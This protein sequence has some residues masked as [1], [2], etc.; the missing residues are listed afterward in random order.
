MGNR[1]RIPKNTADPEVLK[2]EKEET[3][4]IKSLVRDERTHKILGSV[5][6]FLGLFL[7]VAFTSYLFTWMEDQDKVRDMG[8]KILMPNE[9]EISNQLGSLGAFTAFV[10]FE[11]GFGLSSYLFCSLFFVLGSNLMFDKPI[12][13]V[14][15]NLRYLLTG[16][17]IGSVSAAFF[18]PT[19]AFNWGG[20]LGKFAAAWLTAVIGWAGTF[21]LI[22][23]S[24]FSYV[25]W[26]FNPI[27]KWPVFSA[28]PKNDLQDLSLEDSA[29]PPV[30][31]PEIIQPRLDLTEGNTLKPQHALSPL[32]EHPV[33]TAPL[34]VVEKPADEI[35]AVAIAPLD[36]PWEADEIEEESN[37]EA[38]PPLEI[39]PVL[40]EKNISPKAAA[41]LASPRYDPIADLKG[42]KFPSLDLLAQHTG[43]KIVMD[44]HELE[45]NKTQIMSTLRNYDI[46]IQKIFATVGPT[47]TLYEIVPAAGVRISRIKNLEDDIA[48][49]LSAL[50]IRIPCHHATSLDGW[51]NRTR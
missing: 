39:K 44:Q 20:A 13:S 8:A 48:L 30:V 29:I 32:T 26:R 25:I 16:L 31:E 10:F 43:E 9:L 34:E 51:C 47:V 7:F 3:V 19:T 14:A 11:Y 17:I 41:V 1:L 18:T 46:E 33:E 6:L 15:R 42:Y 27:F 38:D 2:E 5:L 4:E 36:V 23:L 12:F 28:K 50:G 49:S 45:A 21:A 37:S 35:E 24:L 22:S 40:D